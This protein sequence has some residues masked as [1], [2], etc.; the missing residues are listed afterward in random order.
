MQTAIDL[1]LLRSLLANFFL[2]LQFNL[3]FC[4]FYSSTTITLSTS[5]LWFPLANALQISANHSTSWQQQRSANTR[6]GLPIASS[7]L[8][9]V[10]NE[11]GPSHITRRRTW[12]RSYLSLQ[13]YQ[14][15]PLLKLLP[16]KTAFQTWMQTRFIYP[17][18]PPN[19]AHLKPASE[20]NPPRPS[21][22]TV[23]AIK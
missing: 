18:N 16:I 21:H 3:S 5:T 17:P 23:L 6:P 22:Q 10:R 1:L 11:F 7:L 12:P 8:C 19:S 9:L 20:L 13:P 15:S 2:E 14:H 4:R